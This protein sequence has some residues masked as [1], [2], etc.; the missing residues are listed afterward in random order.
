MEMRRRRRDAIRFRDKV[1]KTKLLDSLIL[2]FMSDK[3]KLFKRCMR[4]KVINSYPSFSHSRRFAQFVA[5]FC[6]D[7]ANK[8]ISVNYADV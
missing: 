5:T 3:S 6:G 1:Y 2:L 4:K 8:D 7:L